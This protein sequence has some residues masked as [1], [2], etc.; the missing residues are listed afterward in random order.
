MGISDSVMVE[1]PDLMITWTVEGEEV[2]DEG[3]SL[4]VPES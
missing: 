3:R 1:S 4:M 2:E